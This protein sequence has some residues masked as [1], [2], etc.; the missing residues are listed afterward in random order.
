MTA[1]LQ[2]LLPKLATC[3]A[4]SLKGLAGFWKGSALFTRGKSASGKG[5]AAS[6]AT[7]IGERF[8]LSGAQIK[9]VLVAAAQAM[10]SL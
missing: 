8:G 10:E 4:I 3:K 6:L 1:A 5:A 7:K 9:S 2:G